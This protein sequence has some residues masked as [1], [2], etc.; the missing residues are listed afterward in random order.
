MFAR[1]AFSQKERHNGGAVYITLETEDNHE[2]TKEFC[3]KLMELVAAS[4]IVDVNVQILDQCGD[5]AYKTPTS[6]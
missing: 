2:A 5:A 1:F 6:K 3:A 4:P